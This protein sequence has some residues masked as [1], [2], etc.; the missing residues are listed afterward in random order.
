MKKRKEKRKGEKRKGIL[1]HA[2]LGCLAKPTRLHNTAPGLWVWRYKYCLSFD[3]RRQGEW[4][5]IFFG[6]IKS[7][8]EVYI[9]IYIELRRAFL[10]HKSQ[11]EQLLLFGWLWIFEKHVIQE[12]ALRL[13]YGKIYDDLRN[14]Y[15]MDDGLCCKI[16]FVWFKILIF[17]LDFWYWRMAIYAQYDCEPNEGFLGYAYQV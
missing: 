15:E 2:R 6:F 14:E 4:Y 10:L 5:Y 9:C 7:C 3:R 13:I 1:A 12:I 17:G 16:L 11:I 8:L